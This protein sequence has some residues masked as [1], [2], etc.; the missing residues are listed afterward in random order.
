MKN[1][2][3]ILQKAAKAGG[4]IHR[5]LQNYDWMYGQGV[6]DTDGHIWEV[7]WMDETKRPKNS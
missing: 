4:K 1:I 7:F 3:K 5:D 6:E 2:D